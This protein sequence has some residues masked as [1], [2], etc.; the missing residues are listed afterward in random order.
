MRV[1]S[2][3]TTFECLYHKIKYFGSL[4]GQLARLVGLGWGGPAACANRVGLGS[5]DWL[6]G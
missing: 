6:A 4:N 1:I 5:A 2:I 3:A